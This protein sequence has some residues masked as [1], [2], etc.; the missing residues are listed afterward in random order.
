MVSNYVPLPLCPS[1]RIHISIRISLALLI[2]YSHVS[3]QKKANFT[4]IAQLRFLHA[5]TI[6]DIS[7]HLFLRISLTRT[8]T[9]SPLSHPLLT[10]SSSH[11]KFVLSILFFSSSSS[12]QYLSPLSLHLHHIYLLFLFLFTIFIFSTSSSSLYLSP[13]PLHYIS[14]LP[15]P[16]HYLSLFFLFIFSIFLSSSFS[17]SLYLSPLHLPPHYISL[18]YLYLSLT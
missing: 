10:L 13:L 2:C 3:S 18:L 16:L 12:S 7:L 4:T 8:N 14:L 5:Q 17:S 1:L 15:L 9:S 11:L 6:Y